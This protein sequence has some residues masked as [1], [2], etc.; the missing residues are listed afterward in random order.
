M[1]SFHDICP[2]DFSYILL[3]PFYFILLYLQNILPPK[4]FLSHI[5]I[6]NSHT[7][8]IS[9]THSYPINCAT[10]RY[11]GI[12]TNIQIWSGH[13][14][15]WENTTFFSSHNFLM[16]CTILA[17]SF[18]YISFFYILVQTLYDIGV[19]ICIVFLKKTVGLC[20]T[21]PARA[22]LLHPFM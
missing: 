12:L 8:P 3:S 4:S 22:L 9:S 11:G 7:Y 15:A 21:I 2:I 18:F 19:Y 13:T 10:L 6:S 16:I 1:Y 14:C 20:L 17:L 5:Y